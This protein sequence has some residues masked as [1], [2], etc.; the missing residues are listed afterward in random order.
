MDKSSRYWNFGQHV[1]LHPN[2]CQTLAIRYP[3]HPVKTAL[4]KTL[5][6]IIKHKYILGCNITNTQY[7]SCSK[8]LYLSFSFGYSGCFLEHASS[9]FVFVQNL[10]IYLSRHRKD[11]KY[12]T[13]SLCI[14]VYCQPTASH[15]VQLRQCAGFWNLPQRLLHVTADH[16]LKI[17]KV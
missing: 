2:I 4:I 14:N 5:Q 1:E 6:I 8:Y 13:C 7:L 15:L 3:P 16:Q 17:Q 12:L 9:V 11:V 10:S